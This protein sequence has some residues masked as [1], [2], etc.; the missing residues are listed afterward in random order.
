MNL[1]CLKAF[2]DFLNQNAPQKINAIKRIGDNLL[3]FEIHNQCFYFDLTK[4]RSLIFIADDSLIPHK[5]YQ[6]P[7]DKSLQKYCL[8]AMLKEAKIDGFNRILQLFL[9]NKNHNKTNFL[10]EYVTTLDR[11]SLGRSKG[12]KASSISPTCT[13]GPHLGRLP[14]LSQA[15]SSAALELE[16]CHR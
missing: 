3:K 10:K 1:S 4:G 15:I 7:F 9:E 8:K 13:Q 2:A 12:P 11:Y 6:A 16:Q 14:P 5:N